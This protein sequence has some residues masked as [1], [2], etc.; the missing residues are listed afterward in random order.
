[1]RKVSNMISRP[2]SESCVVV[3]SCTNIWYWR[4]PKRPKIGPNSSNGQS[5]MVFAVSHH[6]HFE[7]LIIEFRKDWFPPCYQKVQIFSQL[8]LASDKPFSL[9]RTT[10]HFCSWLPTACCNKEYRQEKSFLDNVK[11]HIFDKT[12]TALAWSIN[13]PSCDRNNLMYDFM[14][15]T[16][17]LLY[18]SKYGDMSKPSNAKNVHSCKALYVIECAYYS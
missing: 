11:V 12:K 9:P 8:A 15:F 4:G 7:T 18:H 17:C 1:M 13:W 10:Y 3:F 14:Q 2:K 16:A 5:E 6:F